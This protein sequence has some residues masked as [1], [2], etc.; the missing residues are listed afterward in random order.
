MSHSINQSMDRGYCRT[1][2]A[3]PGLLNIATYRLNGTR[4]QF[5]E[6]GKQFKL[7]KI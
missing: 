7:K 5:S 2:P 4:G 1:A 6:I 3:T